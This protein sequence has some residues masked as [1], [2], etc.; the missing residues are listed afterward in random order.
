M[1][2]LKK[3]QTPQGLMLHG[4]PDVRPSA[5]FTH[6]LDRRLICICPRL[7]APGHRPSTRSA[8]PSC[9]TPASSTSRSRT[10]S[11]STTPKVRMRRV[12]HC[13]SRTA[14]TENPPQPPAQ[15]EAQR[16]DAWIHGGPETI[17]ENAKQ[18]LAMK[19]WDAARP[20]LATS[21][22]YA[23]SPSAFKFACTR[24]N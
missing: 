18:R 24:C 19:G 23:H 11:P 9:A 3:I 12:N 4:K 13:G 1:N 5:L 16:F 21:V 8:T 7:P 14:L 20:A 10:S 2:Q 6:P 17:L 22:R 15:F